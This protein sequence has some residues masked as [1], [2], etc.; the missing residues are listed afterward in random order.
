[1]SPV[2]HIRKAAW[3]CS[4]LVCNLVNLL[5]AITALGLGGL[6]VLNVFQQSVPVP[7]KVAN[8]IINRSAPSTLQASW[9][10]LA[11]DLRGGFFLKGLLVRNT[12]TEQ[13]VASAEE[14]FIQWSPLDFLIPGVPAVTE[15]DARKIDI[16]VPVS[17]SPSGLNEPV[18]RIDHIHARQQDGFVFLDALLIQTGGLQLYMDGKAPLNS[19]LKAT[20]LSSKAPVPAQPDRN[21][22]S[23]LQQLGRLPPDL[24]VNIDAGWTLQNDGSHQLQVT[25]YL[26]KFTFQEVAVSQAHGEAALS[27]N[28]ESFAVDRVQLNGVLSYMGDIPDIPFF[29]IPDHPVPV[30]FHLAATGQPVQTKH[31]RFPSQI[32]L[33]LHPD[34]PE[35]KFQ[36]LILESILSENLNHPIQYILMGPTAFATGTAHF[37]G[38]VSLGSE[39]DIPDNIDFRAYLPDWTIYQILDAPLP[40]KLLVGTKADH[41][42]FVGS[43][44]LPARHLSGSLIA[45]RL[46][47]AQTNFE[48]LSATLNLSPESI[49]LDDIQV[50]KSRI[51]VASGSYHQHFPSSRFSLNA[52]GLIFPSSLDAILGSWWTN[53]FTNI[54]TAHPLP[55][56]VTV[57]GHWRDLS[58][59]RSV[60]E[61]HGSGASYNG[62]AIPE[63]E[64]RVRSNADW[65]YLDVL[66]AH[67]PDGKIEGK[68]AIRSGLTDAERYRAYQL[69]LASTAPW[70]AVLGAT[71]LEALKILDFRD[72]NPQLR[73]SG[74]MWRDSG[75][76]YDADHTAALRLSLQ[77]R[78]GQCRLRTLELSGLSAIGSV[79]GNMVE[80]NGLSGRFA[81]GIF[82]GHLQIENWQSREKMRKQIDIDLINARYGTAL[83]QLTRF[84]KMSSASAA[85]E[86]D[87]IPGFLDAELSL[88]FGEELESYSGAG[89]LW[90]REGELGTVHMFGELSRLL[91]NLGVG[92]TSV[93]MNTLSL[94]WNLTGPALKISA[95]R[96]TGPAL[97]LTLD[98]W[99]DLETQGL[100]MKSDLT[101]FSGVFSKVLTPVSDTVKLSLGGTIE[102]PDWS[103]RFNP[104]GWAIN[105]LNALDS[106]SGK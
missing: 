49:Q 28:R 103:I 35:I 85:G 69:D 47:I 53:I 81:G 84:V 101:L 7:H 95:G 45:D 82:T 55:G 77:Q 1:M 75:K 87:S 68:I 23:I 15:L 12:E 22:Y 34:N 13:I 71:G 46:N 64:L 67:F 102:D 10:S 20:R 56:D 97:N 50:N 17:H 52:A 98:G 104:F 37:S 33:S 90:I 14:T 18:V 106:G 91:G 38:P 21:I 58:S 57:W 99:V 78:E 25:A 80:L 73:V 105:R 89:N 72:G 4:C 43:L 62:V 6:V 48:R 44:N 16:Y 54:N 86:T 51:E 19:F 94:D 65:A 88:A 26:P 39:L 3:K 2:R 100:Q 61:V 66:R 9:S 5:L 74:T 83:D 27:I 29:N 59:L 63:L 31:G 8:W 79:R 42:R 11:F 60:T 36:H 70:S 76:G 32:H 24:Q 41:I 96:V 40:D 93:E 92:F 30:P